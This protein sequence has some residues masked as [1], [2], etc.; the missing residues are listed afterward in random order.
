MLENP[1]ESLGDLIDRQDVAFIA[2]VDDHGF[3][4]MKAMLPPRRREE[5]RVFYFTTNTSSMRVGH[6][7]ANPKGCIYFC[8]TRLFRGVMFTGLFEILED[9][10]RKNGIWREGDTEYYTLGPTDPD[11]CVLRFTASS[12]RYYSDLKTQTFVLD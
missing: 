12:Y 1:D 5:L 6:Y 11:Y 8:D 3:P 10:D 2:S 7:R 4:A 9:Q